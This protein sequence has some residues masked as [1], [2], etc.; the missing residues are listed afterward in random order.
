MSDKNKI[1]EINL[2]YNVVIDLVKAK[3]FELV[4]LLDEKN[5]N[6]KIIY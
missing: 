5:K 1:K 4:L 6:I 3:I 2:K